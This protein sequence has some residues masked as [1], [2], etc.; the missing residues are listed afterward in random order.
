M[1]GQDKLR[2]KLKA[3][4]LETLPRT[5]L[6]V[7]DS[8]CG[9]HTLVKELS[10]WY[11]VDLIDVS[12]L[13]DSE[14]INEIYL[15]TIN[16]FYLIDVSKLT[17]KSQNIMLKF[18]EEPPQ[19]SHIILISTSKSSVINTVLNRCMV[20][21]FEQYS[22][23]EL[24]YFIKEGNRDKILTYC[25]TPGQIIMLNYNTIEDMESTIDKIID[26]I[27]V[28]GYVNLLTVSNK[29]NYGDEYDKYDIDLF[30]NMFLSKLETAFRENMYDYA[31]KMYQV[32]I[33]YKN[34]LKDSRY[35][36]NLL[37][38]SM[39]TDLWTEIRRK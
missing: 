17:E 12:G 33:K 25:E 6:L 3:F 24:N 28:V 7:G 39:L 19:N 32:V 29:F 26:K 9:K 27:G 22:R 20:Y 15:S 18:L 2:E 34:K 4:T 5:I 38:E 8:G 10:K 14:Y 11:G 35:R 16:M 31:L 1:I 37:I 13:L 36:K 21:E 30:M 23:D